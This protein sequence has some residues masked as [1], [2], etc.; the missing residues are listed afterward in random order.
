MNGPNYLTL[1]RIAMAPLWALLFY[2]YSISSPVSSLLLI[3]LWSLFFVSEFTDILD[4]Y[5]A[6][7]SKQITDLGKVLDPFADVISRLTIFIMLNQEGYLPLWFLML[8]LYRE[9][10][11][12]FL[13]LLFTKQGIAMAAG[14]LGK[15]KA[16]FYFLT[17]L[18]GLMIF[19]AE[20][21]DP[22]FATWFWL[23]SAYRVLF[24]ITALISLWGFSTYI[25][26][27]YKLLKKEKNLKCKL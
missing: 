15:I 22:N 19:S 10:G 4:G 17:S 5:W 24:I 12:V 14:T 8:I 26:S 1:F 2:L 13:R 7:K 20:I 21:W 23:G 16:W 27:Y 6:R 9:L 3:L 18:V 11:A 25:V